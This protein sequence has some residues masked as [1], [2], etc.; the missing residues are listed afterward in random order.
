MVNFQEVEQ[1]I[2]KEIESK[3]L[4]VDEWDL[5][6]IFEDSKSQFISEQVKEL[7]IYQIENHDLLN[8]YSEIRKKLNSIND[9]EEIKQIIKG[10]FSKFSKEDRIKQLLDK[11]PLD[12]G[13]I[14]NKGNDRFY[15]LYDISKDYSKEQAIKQI[16]ESCK[17]EVLISC[18]LKDSYR[19]GEQLRYL[20]QLLRLLFDIKISFTYGHNK[21]LKDYE[22]EINNS[23]K[24]IKVRFFSEWL[25]ISF[26]ND[27]QRQ[28]LLNLI[29]EKRIPQI[30]KKE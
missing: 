1:G 4:K 2:F 14:L 29:I 13:K 11:L 20:E 21:G 30:Y 3:G 25:Y 24:N 5:K 9:S 18:Y 8:G 19:V 23:T 28:K 7:N 17:K 12:V 26:K 6:K 15:S 10:F 16:K 22:S 27:E